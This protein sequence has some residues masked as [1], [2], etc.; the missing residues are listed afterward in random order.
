MADAQD[1]EKR[2][3]EIPFGIRALERGIEV[4]GVWISRSN[5]NTPVSG[6]PASSAAS[7]I[8]DNTPPAKQPRSSPRESSCPEPSRSDPR[9][10]FDRAVDAEPLSSRDMSYNTITP[11]LAPSRAGEMLRRNSSNPYLLRNSTTLD[12]LEGYMRL[13]KRILSTALCFTLPHAANS[14]RARFR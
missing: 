12:A 5:L 7:S 9:S 4:D 3:N 2:R 14:D 1:I 10:S 13:S 6:S 11:K 8:W